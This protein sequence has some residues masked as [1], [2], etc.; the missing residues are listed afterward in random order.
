MLTWDMVG[1]SIRT[2]MLIGLLLITPLVVTLIIVN[3]LFTFITNSLVPQAWLQSNLAVL[4]R[5]AALG[6]VVLGVYLIGFLARNMIGRGLYR[7]GD[8]IMVQIPVIKSIYLAVRRVSESLASSKEV[9]F[10]QVVAIQFP[11]H[12]VYSLGFL[13]ASL[14]PEI[15]RTELGLAEEDDYVNV[16]VPTAPNPTSGFMLIV[17][18]REIKPLKLSVGDAMKMLLSGGAVLPMG[19]DA[20]PQSLLDHL[21]AWIIHKPAAHQVAGDKGRP[22]AH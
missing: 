12:G 15:A 17:S 22:G 19:S 5:L 20:K 8:R 7:L 10:K 11:R 9:M 2:N 18:R 1:K 13:T 3:L 14:P 16:F 4:Y 21:D 6:I